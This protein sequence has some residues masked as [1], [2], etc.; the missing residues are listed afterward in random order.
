MPRQ[1]H[2]VIDEIE[3]CELVRRDVERDDVVVRARLHRY[4]GDLEDI[5]FAVDAARKP[6]GDVLPVAF[7]GCV[8]SRGERRAL[9]CDSAGQAREG[10]IANGRHAISRIE[11]NAIDVIEDRAWILCGPA[12]HA[13]KLARGAARL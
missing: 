2:R 4:P 1:R 13:G 8:G 5:S 6:N 3:R 11:R 9:D 12:G 10:D 7:A